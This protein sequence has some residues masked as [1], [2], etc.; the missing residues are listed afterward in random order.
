MNGL[1]RLLACLRVIPVF[2]FNSIARSVRRIRTTA[3]A[4][5]T[6]LFEHSR[7]SG[8]VMNTTRLLNL[9]F[10]VCA[11]VTGPLVVLGDEPPGE[12]PIEDDDATAGVVRMIPAVD[13]LEATAVPADEQL[14]P[15]TDVMLSLI[16]I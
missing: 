14:S 9:G 5:I 10:L 2:P 8:P 7:S 4:G 16:H 3:I 1:G 13:A 6:G 15:A 12:L 11:L